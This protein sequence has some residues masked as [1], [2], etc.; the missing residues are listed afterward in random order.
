MKG[1]AGEAF[2]LISMQRDYN[3][4]YASVFNLAWYGLQPLPLGLLEVSR[5]PELTD[6]IFFSAFE[7]GQPGY[8]H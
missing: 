6:G 1:L 7:E 5:A 3:A 2:D 8:Q 4:S